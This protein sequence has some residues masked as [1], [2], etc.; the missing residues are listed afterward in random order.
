M[1]HRP[2]HAASHGWGNLG[3]IVCGVVCGVLCGALCGVSHGFFGGLYCGPLLVGI[4][5]GW[6]ASAASGVSD[7][8]WPGFEPAARARLL[9]KDA[10]LWCRGPEAYTGFVGCL[11]TAGGDSDAGDWAP[12]EPRP[13]RADQHARRV[14]GV[15]EDGIPRLTHDEGAGF[16]NLLKAAT[17]LAQQ[18]GVNETCFYRYQLMTKTTR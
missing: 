2:G 9:T 11:T 14:S 7:V 17:R 18:R 6:V 12:R 4:L 10:P 13:E 3:S 5:V 15:A 16:G 8:L 1:G